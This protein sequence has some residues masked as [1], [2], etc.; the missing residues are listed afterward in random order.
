MQGKLVITEYE[1]RIFAILFDEKDNPLEINLL[2]DE[3]NILGNVYVAKVKNIV[4]N[5]NAAFL[6]FDGDN[7]GYLALNDVRNAIFINNKKNTDIVSGDEILVQISK[8][9]I[10]EK[11]PVLTT[12]INV[13]GK[14]AVL[15]FNKKDLSISKK[16]T[17]E[18]RRDELKSIFVP[19]IC[20]EFNFVVRTNAADAS[21]EQI[22]KEIKSL[23]KKWEDIKA[24]AGHATPFSLIYGNTS[25]YIKLIKNSY[26]FELSEIVTDL[27]DVYNDI[28]GY[29]KENE[30]TAK[31]IRF[32]KD[33]SLSLNKLF[34]FEKII[35]DAL[36]DKVWLKSGGYLVI[37]PTEALTVIDVNSGKN[38]SGKDKDKEILKLN[39]EAATKIAHQLRLRNLSGIIMIDFV[40]MN[41]KEA[42]NKLMSHLSALLNGDP[43]Q[44]SLVDITK[45]GIV[46]VTRKKIKKPLHE[47][48]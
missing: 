12:N 44:A 27:E 3:N 23:I 22:E 30:E 21:N 35:N 28:N 2:D 10:K 43:V 20:D 9:A 1:N 16:I 31:S 46:E 42:E 48:V 5:I 26:D 7:Q 6:S 24:R 37:E 39:I 40:N 15:V 8:E 45:L 47:I 32:Y 19:F 34:R 14:Y 41:D 4:K 17:S 13:S 29:L 33:E 25:P 38:I 36:S 11:E 18:K